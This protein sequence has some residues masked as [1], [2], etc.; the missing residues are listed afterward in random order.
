MRKWLV[1][2][3]CGGVSPVV[4]QSPM[5]PVGW[6]GGCWEQRTATRVVH[7]QWMAPLGGMMLGMSR[8]VV[9]DTARAFEQLRIEMRDGKLAYV[10]KPSRQAET[11]FTA[12]QP[13]D[14]L[15]VFANPQHDFPQRISYR[16]IG[17]DSLVA[18]IEGDQGGQ[19]R[20]INFPMVRVACPT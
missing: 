11:T 4:A 13:T 16:K 15:I 10:A 8:T 17:P 14:T 19:V 12:D 18:R 20:G 5:A 2:L 9:R 7:E 6:L 3:A 1:L